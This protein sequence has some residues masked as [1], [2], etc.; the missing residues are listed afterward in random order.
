MLEVCLART[1]FLQGGCEKGER[2]VSNKKYHWLLE[3]GVLKSEGRLV[4]CAFVARSGNHQAASS[5]RNVQVAIGA[6]LDFVTEQGTP[7]VFSSCLNTE[8]GSKIQGAA[9]DSEAKRHGGESGDMLLRHS[10]TPRQSLVAR[11]ADCENRLKLFNENALP[12]L[13]QT[14]TPEYFH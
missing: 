12:A 4:P 9:S 11:D 8:K 2:Y 10:V 6:F 5:P 7:R 3:S 13:Q 1:P 14:R